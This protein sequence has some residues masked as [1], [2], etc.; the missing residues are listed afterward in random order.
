MARKK[1]HSLFSV[2]S[3]PVGLSRRYRAGWTRPEYASEP[4]PYSGGTKLRKREETHRINE[5][6]VKNATKQLSGFR[7]RL[8]EFE[9]SLFLYTLSYLQYAVMS[10]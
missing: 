1:T 3:K 10:E 4:E 5:G 6:E 2:E 8:R 9:T 7:L